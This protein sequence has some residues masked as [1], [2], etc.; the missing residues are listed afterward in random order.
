M[1]W[2]EKKRYVG[3]LTFLCVLKMALLC[4]K[5]SALRYKWLKSYKEPNNFV[6]ASDIVH[7]NN[8]IKCY[9]LILQCYKDWCLVLS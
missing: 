3:I 8:A 7:T 9:L 4:A 6:S 2:L 5:Y 1:K